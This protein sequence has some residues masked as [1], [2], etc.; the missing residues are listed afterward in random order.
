MERN[1]IVDLASGSLWLIAISAAFAMLSLFLI[2]TPLA[3]AVLL[4]VAAAALGLI[5]LSVSVIRAATSL[6]AR[7]PSTAQP[8]ARTRRQFVATVGGEVVALGAVNTICVA[9]GRVVAVAPLDIIIVGVHFFP[10]ARIFRRPRYY[11]MGGCFCIVPILTM[12]MIPSTARVD[13]VSAWFVV[14][15]LVCSFWASATG[16]IGLMD[17]WRATRSA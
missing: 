4:G 8:R 2:G 10:L 13:Q 3:M 17:A 6:P 1:G 9:T 16:A 7:A 5:I 15:S 12:A 11:A 14:P